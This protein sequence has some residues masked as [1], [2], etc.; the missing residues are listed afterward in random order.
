MLIIK[1]IHPLTPQT[2]N[3]NLSSTQKAPTC[4]LLLGK[5]DRRAQCQV[6]QVAVVTAGSSSQ[7]V[8]VAVSLSHHVSVHVLYVSNWKFHKRSVLTPHSS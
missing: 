4:P 5:G 8:F 1:E 6:W 2:V 3:D 7:L